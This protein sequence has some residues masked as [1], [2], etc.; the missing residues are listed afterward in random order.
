VLSAAEGAQARYRVRECVL[1]PDHCYDLLPVGI[2]LRG[3]RRPAL[4][5]E[6]DSIAKTWVTPA[7]YA[8]GA[9][10]RFYLGQVHRTAAIMALSR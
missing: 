5:T 6:R 1:H 7:E 2:T 3:V 8:V 10:W 4:V 9:W